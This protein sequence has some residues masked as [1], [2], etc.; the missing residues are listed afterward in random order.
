MLAG[1][2]ML[3][4]SYPLALLVPANSKWGCD[5]RVHLTSCLGGSILLAGLF[6]KGVPRRGL[7]SLL[8]A[9]YFVLLLGRCFTIQ[10]AY[11]QAWEFQQSF[12]TGYVT[13]LCLPAARSE[14]PAMIVLSNRSLPNN[15][16]TGVLNWSS[17][18]IPDMLVR[19]DSGRMEAPPVFV[20]DN[21]E[22]STSLEDIIHHRIHPAACGR[23]RWSKELDRMK[24]LKVEL[25]GNWRLQEAVVDSAGRIAGW[26]EWVAPMRPVSL[27]K[28]ELCQL[29]VRE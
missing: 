17:G 3:M 18:I 23:K 27:E 22:E 25:D 4:L 19:L 14:I 26:K 2:G 7:R 9:G 1:T 21:L 10:S 20:A 12:W 24:V 28:K 16:E 5:T 29:L 13:R 8:G 6:M 15:P 11:T